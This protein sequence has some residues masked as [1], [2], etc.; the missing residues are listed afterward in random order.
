MPKTDY[1][2]LIK[3]LQDDDIME[4][5]RTHYPKIHEKLIYFI[6]KNFSPSRPHKYFKKLNFNLTEIIE[7]FPRTLQHEL[8][9]RYTALNHHL[10]NLRDDY[11]RLI[12]NSNYD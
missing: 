6:I 5:I 8:I 3:H 7:C 11:Y 10:R 12:Y 2:L 4:I 1:S 9:C